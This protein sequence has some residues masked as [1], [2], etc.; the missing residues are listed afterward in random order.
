MAAI[1]QLVTAHEDTV[2]DVIHAFNDR[3]LAALDPRWAGGRPRLISD[4]DRER[5]GAVPS[6]RPDGPR[7]PGG[8]SSGRAVERSSGRAVERSSG[9]AV[10]R[11]SGRRTVPA[12][13]RGW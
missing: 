12:G 7:W 13:S 4:E 6:D 1:A 10:E 9:R 5:A 8:R 3:G 11:S 2:R